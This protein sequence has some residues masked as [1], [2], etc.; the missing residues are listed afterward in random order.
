[1]P[2][3]D[4]KRVRLTVP[5]E[6][7][8]VLKWMARQI[9]LSLS[10]RMAIREAVAAHGYGDMTCLP[11]VRGRGR[12]RTRDEFDERYADGPEEPLPQEEPVRAEPRPEPKS[13]ERPKGPSV[14]QPERD[15]PHEVPE[16]V[17][18]SMGSLLI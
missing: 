2:S 14:L 7:E 10:I 17:P 8:I 11:A 13:V 15:G 12:P 16:G 18:D 9:N 3:A 6:D 1:M 4:A 5:A